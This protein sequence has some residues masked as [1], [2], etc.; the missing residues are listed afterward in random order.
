MARRL[1]HVGIVVRNIEEALEVYTKVLGFN[2]PPAGIVTVP[3]TGG[4]YALLP[5]GDNY[6]ELIESTHPL[7]SQYLEQR[8]EGLYHF[9]VEVDDIDAEVKS[10]NEKGVQ[11]IEVPRG[12]IIDWRMV[13][14]MP[15]S[16]KGVPLEFAPKGTAHKTQRKLLGLE[17]I[18]SPLPQ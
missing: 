17:V 12:E 6:I 7:V 9:V 5:I 8:G 1:S 16:A 4:K 10:L 2:A 13:A 3:E 14:L 11:V 18:D 15:E